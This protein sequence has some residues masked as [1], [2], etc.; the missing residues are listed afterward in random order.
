[1]SMA[2]PPQG[3]LTAL[4][5]RPSCRLKQRGAVPDLAYWLEPVERFGHFK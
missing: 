5:A 4:L 3:S 2:V 1:M